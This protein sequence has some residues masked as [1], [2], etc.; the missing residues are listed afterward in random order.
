MSVSMAVLEP[1]E[2][3]RFAFFLVR[4]S[5]DCGV[6]MRTGQQIHSS[7][8]LT[9]LTEPLSSLKGTASCSAFCLSSMM[10]CA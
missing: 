4:S 6:S 7:D 8:A 2:P 1:L 3:V 10:Y 5:C 9:V